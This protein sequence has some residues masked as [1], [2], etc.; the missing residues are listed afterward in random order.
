MCPAGVQDAVR[1]HQ[2]NQLTQSTDAGY[3]MPT[4]FN[5]TD[6]TNSLAEPNFKATRW[7]MV[8]IIKSQHR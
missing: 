8:W 3:G 2:V 6:I 7:V 4:L 5:V 1:S